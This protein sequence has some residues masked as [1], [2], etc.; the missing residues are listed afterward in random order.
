MVGKSSRDGIRIDPDIADPI[1]VLSRLL[2]T[3]RC[4]LTALLQGSF[5]LILC[6]LA[7]DISNNLC[8]LGGGFPVILS[9]LDQHFAFKSYILSWTDLRLRFSVSSFDYDRTHLSEYPICV[10]SGRALLPSTS[11]LILSSPS[12]SWETPYIRALCCAARLGRTLRCQWE[13]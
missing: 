12:G 8:F 9:R 4:L 6:F 1:I 2:T 11:N 3:V 13:T 7:E 10:K 5:P